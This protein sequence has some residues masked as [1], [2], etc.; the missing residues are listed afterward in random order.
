MNK[1]IT[2]WLFP[3]AA[4][5]VLLVMVAW[6]AGS[7]DDKVPPGQRA[8]SAPDTSDAVV[9]ELQSLP[10]FEAVPAS[11]EAKQATLIAARL[12]ARIEQV[13]VRA[14]D[15]VK[16]GDLLVVLERGD[17][18]SRVSQA[19]ANVQSA[20]ARYTEA[21][22]A[23][24]RARDLA[25]RGLLAQAD[26]DRAQAN[27]DSLKAGQASAEQA[28]QEAKTALDFAEVR[29]PIAGRIVDRFAEPGDTAQ[30]GMTLLSLYNPDYLRVEANVREALALSLSL[31][32]SL[33]VTIPALDSERT[34]VIEELVPAGNPGS[35]SFLIKCRLDQGSG[36]LPGLYARLQVPAGESEVLLIAADRIAEVGQLDLAWVV[37]HDGIERRILRLGQRYADGRVAVVAGLQAGEQ[38]LPPGSATQ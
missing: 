36:L 15:L 32:Q 6:M 19:E 26:L 12:L 11:V 27:H 25:E 31:G 16:A 10:L 28:L 2:K 38:V 8:V 21:Q 17:L 5:V 9:V 3:V 22:Q 23:L 30:P 14:G 1:S 4:V 34:A 13:K 7:F 35:R 37:G 24:K 29:A 20:S 18:Q 33:T